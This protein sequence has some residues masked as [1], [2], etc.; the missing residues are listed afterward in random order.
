MGGFVIQKAASARR[1]TDN[2]KAA[3]ALTKEVININHLNIDIET[4]SSVDIKK[5]G[6]YKYAMS[7][8]FEILLFAY[9]LNGAPVKV[10][11]LAF[12][13]QVPMDI[14]CMLT[15][16]DTVKHAFNAAFEW[17]CLS[18]YLK[19]E[20]SAWVNQWRCTQLHG[21]YCGYTTGLGATGAAMGLAQDKQKDRAGKALIDYFC[22][23]CK[24]TK[25]NGERTRNMPRHAPE[26]WNLFIEY[27][28]QDVVTESEIEKRLSGFPVPDDVQKQ[29]ETDLIINYRG[30]ALD[31][32]LIRGALVLGRDESERL[33]NEA[34]ELTGLSNPNSTQ[35]LLSWLNE[36]GLDISD[37]QK[38]TI[39]QVLK[40]DTLTYEIRKVLEIRAGD[41]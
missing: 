2:A 28:R 17:F 41:E 31:M 23:P 34:K 37:L 40:T 39:A 32:D 20:P 3:N 13:E 25:A 6:L 30:V 1:M 33:I 19:I 36:H 10:V 27:N 11:D 16:R 4:Y 7:D 35:Q 38:G 22:K 12:G 21:L 24:P 15:D 14:Y 5:S 8:D 9:S 18:R 29:W 26:K